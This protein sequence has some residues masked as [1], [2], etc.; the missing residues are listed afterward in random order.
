M[1]EL[2]KKQNQAMAMAMT[3]TMTVR[4]FRQWVVLTWL[5]LLYL[6][7]VVVLSVVVVVGSTL[8]GGG[9]FLVGVV[10]RGVAHTHTNT[11]VRMYVC[12]YE[13]AVVCSALLFGGSKM[14]N[15]QFRLN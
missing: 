5:A 4:C 7:F 13:R 3:M 1:I 15:F 8:V 11:Y 10:W 12:M 6:F 2:E 14:Y 9:W